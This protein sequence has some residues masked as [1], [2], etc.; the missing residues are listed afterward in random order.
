MLITLIGGGVFAYVT[1]RR[2]EHAKR[3]SRLVSLQS[4]DREL[5]DAYRAVKR[6]KRKMRSRLERH[7]SHPPR[8][9]SETFTSIMD[10]LLDAQ[11]DLEEVRGHISIRGDLLEPE[12]VER[13]SLSLRYASRYLHDVFEDFERGR[14][15]KDGDRYVIDVSSSNIEGF[16]IDSQI[17]R[18]AKR[19]LSHFRSEGLTVEQR[20][21]ALKNIDALRSAES[22]QDVRYG[23]VAMECL[24]FSSGEIH[25]VIGSFY[26]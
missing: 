18:D 10:E 17:P 15:R 6:V 26:S 24:R 12:V 16:L 20:I 1:A 19:F 5:G 22:S 4:L 25:R 21:E 13:L 23:E 14:T 2:E 9:A 8:M 3:E 11:I 7:P